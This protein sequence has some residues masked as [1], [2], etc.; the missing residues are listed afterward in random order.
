VSVGKVAFELAQLLGSGMRA[1]PHDEGTGGCP[2]RGV[3]LSVWNND[4]LFAGI[5]E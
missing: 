5:A 2:N 1:K 4:E 3:E